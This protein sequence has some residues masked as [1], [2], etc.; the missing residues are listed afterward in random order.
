MFS[1]RTKQSLNNQ[2]KKR[3]PPP[4]SKDISED[5][6]V[7]KNPPTYQQMWDDALKVMNEFE[8]GKRRGIKC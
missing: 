1:R 3:L 8:S 7:F 2:I 5:K 6:S 4:Q